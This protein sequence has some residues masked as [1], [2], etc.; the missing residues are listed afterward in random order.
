MSGIVCGRQNANILFLTKCGERRGMDNETGDEV[1]S[2]MAGTRH[3]QEDQA[4]CKVDN[5][6]HGLYANGDCL[7]NDQE[8]I[9]HEGEGP[10]GGSIDA[11][12][13]EASSERSAELI[14]GIR[15]THWK[16]LLPAPDS[17][18]AYPDWVQHEIVELAKRGVENTTEVVESSIVLDNEESKRLDAL[19]ET[20]R[21]QMRIAQIGTITINLALV[22]GAVILGVCGQTIASSA[23]VGG[24]AAVNVATLLRRERS[25]SGRE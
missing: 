20:D 18:N 13:P 1:V 17:F 14:A 9:C 15:E 16:G 12:L 21:R 2:D 22:V 4:D 24:L 3:E 11:V 25:D 5:E 23:M 7:P 19:V 8:G 10:T 6:K